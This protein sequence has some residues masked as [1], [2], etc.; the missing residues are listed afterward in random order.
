MKALT[1]RDTPVTDEALNAIAHL[2]TKSL[3]KIVDD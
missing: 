2:L 3:S 1:T